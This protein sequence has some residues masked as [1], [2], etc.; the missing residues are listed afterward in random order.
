MIDPF[1]SP[2]DAATLSPAPKSSPPEGESGVEGRQLP[3]PSQERQSY[4]ST[5]MAPVGVPFCLFP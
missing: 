5:S 2:A 1:H 4:Y 3:Y